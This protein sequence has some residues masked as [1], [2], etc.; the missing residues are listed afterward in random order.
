VGREL[1]SKFKILLALLLN[2]FSIHGGTALAVHS[3]N[4]LQLTHSQQSGEFLCES[5]GK[6][7]TP[8]LT[9]TNTLKEWTPTTAV[10]GKQ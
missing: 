4:E 9:M 8:Q 5:L 10:I 2:N 1:D 6:F 3:T 7:K